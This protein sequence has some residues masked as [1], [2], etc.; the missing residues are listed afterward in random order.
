M[1]VLC[2]LHYQL[3]SKAQ[4]LSICFSKKIILRLWKSEIKRKKSAKATRAFSV[5]KKI[6]NFLNIG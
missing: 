5:A 2:L 6:E 4:K 3:Y 1:I